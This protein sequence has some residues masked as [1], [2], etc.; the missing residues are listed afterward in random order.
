[1]ETVD[2]AVRELPILG[3]QL[4]LDFAN[5][6]DDPL[7]PRRHDH[8]ADYADLLAWARRVSI[9]P[10]RTAGDLER[11]AEAHPRRATAVVRRAAALRDALNETFGALADGHSP[12]AGWQRLRPYVTT[13]LA[14]A[15]LRSDGDL[16]KPAWEFAE[17]ESPLWPVAQAAY[18]LLTSPDLRRLKRCA[19]CP[20][21]FLDQSKN[22]S[23]RWCSMDDCGKHEKIR[24]YVTR[25]AERRRG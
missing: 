23:R 24:K 22:G 2:E 13:A 18:D 17:L 1:M 25:R 8:V 10:P 3:G 11:A 21:L 5:T 19:G 20:W 6:V 4:G 15:T 12:A 9:V 7:G 16:V 14:H